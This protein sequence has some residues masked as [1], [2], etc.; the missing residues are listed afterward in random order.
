LS[1]VAMSRHSGARAA[2]AP[3]QA[4][5][6]LPV[7]SSQTMGRTVQFPFAMAAVAE[8]VSSPGVLASNLALCKGNALPGSRGVV[9]VSC[10][11][12]RHLK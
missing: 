2:W 6:Q 11:A 7:A 1:G 8:Q 3:V 4:A 10:S 5:Q 12:V 9:H